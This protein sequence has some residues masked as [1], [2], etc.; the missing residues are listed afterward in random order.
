MDVFDLTKGEREAFGRILPEVSNTGLLSL[1][2]QMQARTPDLSVVEFADL[3][4]EI[5]GNRLSDLMTEEEA[6]AFL[7]LCAEGDPV[8]AESIFLG[9]GAFP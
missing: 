3:L 6:M 8:L 4:E 7:P 5:T 1:F 2:L 9:L